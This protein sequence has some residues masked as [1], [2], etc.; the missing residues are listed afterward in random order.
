MVRLL[1]K[2]LV[3]VFVVVG[4]SGVFG[5]LVMVVIMK[6]VIVNGVYLIYGI[7]EDGNIDYEIGISVI[8]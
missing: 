2:F 6:N 5:V 3:S 7:N 1:N 4:L 8:D